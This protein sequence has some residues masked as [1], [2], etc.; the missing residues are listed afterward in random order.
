MCCF[1]TDREK[2]KFLSRFCTPTGTGEFPSC[3]AYWNRHKVRNSFYILGEIEVPSYFCIPKKQGTFLSFF[4]TPRKQ[5]KFL[6]YFCI[7][8]ETE[9]PK[10]FC[11]PRKQETFLSFFCKPGE[12]EDVPKLL[13]YTAETQVTLFTG[14]NRSS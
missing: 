1:C 9:V 5:K 12:R 4:C 6:S 7:L 8:G 13:L 3:S 10:Y 2:R 14:R 11:I